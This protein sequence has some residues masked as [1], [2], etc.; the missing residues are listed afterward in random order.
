MCAVADR[1]LKL[2]LTVAALANAVSKSDS[3]STAC[4]VAKQS[5]SVELLKAAV[6]DID[7]KVSALS[8]N[9]SV[10]ICQLTAVCQQLTASVASRSRSV[11]SRR[12]AR[13][14]DVAGRTRQ[15]L[16]SCCWP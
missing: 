11:R 14:S 1:Q 4:D 16:A 7:T 6:D 12:I 9:I 15:G 8:V 13:Q 5:N 2:E 3:C 10:Q